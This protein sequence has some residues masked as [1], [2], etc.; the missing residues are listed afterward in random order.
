MNLRIYTYK[1]TF[2]ETPH[3]YY[4]VHKEKVFDEEYLGSPITH[5][6]MWNFYTPEKQ[7]LQVFDFTDEGY[8]EAQEVEKRIIRQFIGDKWCLNENCGGIFSLKSCS[9]AGKKGSL[10]TM[11]KGVGLFGMDK[12]THIKGS[13]KG[14]QTQKKNKIGLFGA[15]REQLI[16]WGKRGALGQSK[17]ELCEAGKKGAQKSNSQKW[18]CTITGYISNAGGLASYHKS[19]GIDCLNRIKIQ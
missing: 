15:S 2:L 18:K 7:I 17:K 13:K 8:V 11:K 10:V 6:W 4:G 19:K 9:D 14:T 5:K 1:I 16:E 12:E 3:Y